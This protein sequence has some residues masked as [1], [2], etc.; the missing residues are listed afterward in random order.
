MSFPIQLTIFRIVLVPV[1]FIL[2][3]VVTPAAMGWAVVVFVLAAASDWW[4]GYVARKM[5]LTSSLGAFL[6][7]LAD[8]LLTG[9]A[10]VAFAMRGYIVWWMALLVIGRDIYLTVFRVAS[11]DAGL[12]LKTSYFAKVKTFVQ[13]LF[14]GILLAAL[15]AQQGTLGPM[16]QSL[17]TYFL[18][19]DVLYWSMSIVT[20]LTV[21]SA[22]LYSYDNWPA[23]RATGLRYLLRR[24]PSETI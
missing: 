17:S 18:L 16:L 14:I 15:L 5:N 19:S 7:P 23:L 9:S 22:L 11:D 12:P 20:V 2:F 6:D 13:M 3:A 4:D 24:A 10:F 8:K 1:F 21:A